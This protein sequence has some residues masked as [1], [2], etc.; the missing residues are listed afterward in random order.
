MAG[1]LVTSGTDIGDLEGWGAREC[2]SG[3]LKYS[4]KKTDRDKT[5]DSKNKL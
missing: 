3:F 2:Y 4:I 5:L 1:F